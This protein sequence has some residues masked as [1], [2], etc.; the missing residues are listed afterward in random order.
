MENIFGMTA[1]IVGILGA[2]A[3]IRDTYYRKTKPH[4]FAW[5][6]FLLISVISF[7]SQYALG[8]KASL[9]YAGWFVFN[10][11]IIFG[12]SLRRNGGYGGATP[13]NI[14]G[15][16]LALGS[17]ILWKIFASPFAA[18]ISVLIAEIIGALM[19]V[20][21]SYKHPQTETVAMWALGIVGAALMGLSVGK[22]DLAL[23]AFPAYLFIANIAIVLAIFIGK[24]RQ[25][26]KVASN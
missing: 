9:F 23:L 4:R 5:F 15:L 11:I 2:I 22:F 20:F 14:L 13:I 24:Y 1:G 25:K 12:L 21:K 8:A 6:I 10:N 26:Y 7:T 18:L 16:I 3:Y 17:I 19:I